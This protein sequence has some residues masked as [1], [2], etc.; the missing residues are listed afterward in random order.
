VWVCKERPIKGE[1]SSKIAD[2]GRAHFN[3]KRDGFISWYRA[4]SASA[5]VKKS[6]GVA[7]SK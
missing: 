6:K 5:Y 2:W 4:G 7:S 1:K 3:L